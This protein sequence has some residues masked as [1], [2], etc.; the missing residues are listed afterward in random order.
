[1]TIGE[2]E[3][4]IID[5]MMLYNRNIKA[6]AIEIAKEMGHKEVKYPVMTISFYGE[7]TTLEEARP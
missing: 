6:A 4:R 5:L 3:T 1:M 2:L 7:T